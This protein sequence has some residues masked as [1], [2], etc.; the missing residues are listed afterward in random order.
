MDINK[1]IDKYYKKQNKYISNKIDMDNT[2]NIKFNKKRLNIMEFYDNDGELSLTSKYVFYGFIN[3]NNEFIWNY[4]IYGFY[5]DDMISVVKNIKENRE[6]FKTN[7]E[8][9]NFY[10]NLLNNDKLKIKNEKEIEWINKLLIYFNKDIFH[11]NPSNSNNNIQ[12]IGVHKIK[13]LYL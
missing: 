10:R 11:V 13:E 3:N 5:N 4:N 2:F 7:S 9:D 12:F 8:R 6:L 1:K